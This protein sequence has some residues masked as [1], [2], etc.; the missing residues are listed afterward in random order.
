MK[1]FLLALLVTVPIF[2]AISERNKYKLNNAMGQVARQAN[3][4]TILDEGGTRG[5]AKDG[6]QPKQMLVGTYDFATMGG[7][8]V[9]TIELGVSLPDNA[10]VTKSYIDVLT[11]PAGVGATIAI[12][13][14]SAA[15]IKAAT[16]I[17]SY[18]GFVAGE[19][20]GS[21][22]TAFVKTTA[23]RALGINIANTALTAGKFKV[24][25]EYVVSE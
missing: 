5:V 18:S 15:D 12:R 23:E 24:Y 14:E 7:G 17:A 25:L 10:I 19:Q 4:G 6:H 3:L 13:T 22:V 1:K 20:T 16:A 9:G 21:G 2:G 8:S 11:A